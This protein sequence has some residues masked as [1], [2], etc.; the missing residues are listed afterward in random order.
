M[1]SKTIV[2]TTATLMLASGLFLG[3]NSYAANDSSTPSQV[4][5]VSAYT[6]HVEDA[7]QKLHT[8]HLKAFDKSLDSGQREKARRE[9]FTIS[10]GLVQEIHRRIMALN[11]KE[12]AALSHTDVL[13][14]T[15]L[16]MMVLDML[17]ELQKE[18]YI[19]PVMRQ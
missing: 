4:Y 1:K 15:H 7:M 10:Q 5:D 12:G 2:I 11:V 17:S 9:F 8:L 6:K 19:D 14:N 16:T 13:L 3:T 18:S